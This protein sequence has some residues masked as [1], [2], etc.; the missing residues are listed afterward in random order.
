MKSAFTFDA[1]GTSWVITT[2]QAQSEK[3]KEEILE[4]IAEFDKIYSRFRDDS[5]VAKI[6]ERAGTFTFPADGEKLFA[7][8]RA[9]HDATDGKMTPLIGNMLVDAGYDAKYSLTPKDKIRSVPK[10]DEVMRYEHPTLTT[11]VPV[12]L[13][14]GAAGKGYL[15]DIVSEM[16]E[17]YGFAN[18]TVNAGGDIRHRSATNTLLRVG[19]ENPDDT[20]QVIGVAP[21][22]NVSI[23]ASAGSRR[24]WRQYH[25]IMDPLLQI[26]PMHLLG[27]WVIAE[28]T[29]LADALTTALFFA[30]A[31]E[32]RKK[33]EFEY[34]LLHSDHRA[35]KSSGFPGEIFERAK[36]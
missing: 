23:C 21:I 28:S 3:T 1:I 14:F 31:N 34:L 15:I 35:E 4:R 33:F 17:A 18:Y 8:Y 9:M 36:V 2:E 24:R 16:L 27:V 5:L 30:S 10:W 19:L 11:T 6:A 12:L 32:L 22:G 20:T 7:M 26:S 13:D 25:H 29:I